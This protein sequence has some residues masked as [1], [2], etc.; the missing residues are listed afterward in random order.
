MQ[1]IDTLRLLPTNAEL[2]AAATGKSYATSYRR[3]EKMRE[4]GYVV[5]WG[6]D[7]TST[8]RLVPVYHITVNGKRALEEWKAKKE[9]APKKALRTS[10]VEELQTPRK[11]G[12]PPKITKEIA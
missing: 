2:Y 5:Q 8:G 12:R 4:K 11:R 7:I 3:L 6:R 10:G 1:Y 9:V